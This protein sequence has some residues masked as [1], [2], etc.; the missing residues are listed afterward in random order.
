MDDDIGT[1][2]VQDEYSR[3]S[4]SCPYGI[5]SAALPRRPRRG[6]ELHACGG[7]EHIAQPALS[8]QIRKLE[9][10][11]GVALVERTTRHVPD[12]GRPAAGCT[13]A[14][15][16]GRVG[17]RPVRARGAAGIDRGHVT[18]GAIHTM[19]PI[20]LSLALPSSM[21][22]IRVA[23]IVREQSSEECAE[24]L[25]IDELDLAFLSVTERVE[26]HGLGLHQLISEE[27]IVLLPLD[28]RAGAPDGPDGRARSR[29]VHQLPPGRAAARAVVRPAATPVRAPG[30]AR[31]QREP[32][33]PDARLTRPRGRHPARSD[34]VARRRVAVARLVAP[35]CGATSRSPGAGRRHS[36]AA[37]A[38]IEL[39]RGCSPTRRW[40]RACPHRSTTSETDVP[41]CAIGV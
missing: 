13:G 8:Q 22:A 23:L 25:R 27:L 31:V 14:P 30:D 18:I 3:L 34:A 4:I 15:D 26:S 28:H 11:V 36:P 1:L 12:R 39:A 17:L 32:P 21:R 37:Q 29:A 41:N 35:G 16:P 10:E 6:I 40:S 2:D 24:L 20:D 19:G 7:A 5:A 38:S 33:N 9:D